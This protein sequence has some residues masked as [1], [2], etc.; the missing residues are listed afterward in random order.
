M[1][2]SSLR[3]A[4]FP[5]PLRGGV[6]GC[7]K[8]RARPFSDRVQTALR[9]AFPMSLGALRR[10]PPPPSPPRKGEGGSAL[11]VAAG[12]ILAVLSLSTSIAA[13]REL[14]VCADPNNLPFSN[15]A[16]EGFENKI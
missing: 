3:A 16:R 2:S 7:R 10:R 4:L 15:E 11:S 9:G 6:R 13:A 5:S 1:C 8:V 14:R 12:A